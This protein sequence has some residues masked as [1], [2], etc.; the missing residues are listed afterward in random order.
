MSFSCRG[1]IGAGSCKIMLE[2]EAWPGIKLQAPIVQR[3]MG[4]GVLG[5]QTVIQYRSQDHVAK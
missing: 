5:W 4:G 3:V 2:E 1:G